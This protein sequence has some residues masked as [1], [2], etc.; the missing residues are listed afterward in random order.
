MRELPG[1]DHHLGSIGW[2]AGEY[3]I[4]PDDQF[5][6]P[7]TIGL[8]GD[9]PLS[10]DMLTSFCFRRPFLRH[11]K[12]PRMRR[13]LRMVARGEEQEAQDAQCEHNFHVYTASANEKTQRRRAAELEMQTGRAIRR[14]LK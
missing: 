14:P 5:R 8:I 13:S 9:P 12:A 10:Y 1:A 3:A 4:L 11:V 6:I 7:T 2:Y